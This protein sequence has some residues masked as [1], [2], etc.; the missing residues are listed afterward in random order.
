MPPK[1]IKKASPKRSPRNSPVRIVSIS[2]PADLAKKIKSIAFTGNTSVSGL[3]ERALSVYIGVRS[4]DDVARR[5]NR[6][7]ITHKRRY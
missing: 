4:N 2:L 1:R 5:L 3:V 7:G 6:E